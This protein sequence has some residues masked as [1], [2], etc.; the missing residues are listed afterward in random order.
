MQPLS[1]GRIERGKREKL[2]RIKRAARRLFGRKGFEATTTREIAA[3]ADIGAGTLFL[4]VGTKE[5]LLVLIFRE[6]IGRVVTDAFATMPARPLLEQVLHLFGAMIALHERDRGLA[7]VFV[8]E[9][10]FVEDRRHGVAEMMR[11]MLAGIANLIEQ[12]KARGEIRADVPATRLADSL[13]SL[14]FSQLQRWLGGDPITSGQRDEDLRAALKLQLEG[15]RSGRP[16]ALAI[17]RSRR[18]VRS[19]RTI[20]ARPHVRGGR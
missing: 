7:R 9:L 17:K 6:E 10:P 15:L 5:D 13:F 16:K 2:E 11:S 14:Y 18:A 3:A 19:T 8:R 1:T 4:Y 20:A 12:S